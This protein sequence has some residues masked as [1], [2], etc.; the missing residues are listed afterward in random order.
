MKEQRIMCRINRNGTFT[1]SPADTSTMT[2]FTILLALFF[3]ASLLPQNTFGQAAA[4]GEW[5]QLFN[6][7]NLDGWTPKIR[8]HDLGENYGNTFRVEDGLLK[9]GYENYDG[10]GEQFWAFVFQRQFFKLP[11]AGGVS[12]R[13]RPV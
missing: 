6:G 9:V 3:V 2:R 7:K 13:R 8:Y 4:E 5:I 12:I 10:F 11:N 1:L